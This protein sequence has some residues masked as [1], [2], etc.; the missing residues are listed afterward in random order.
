MGRFWD[1]LGQCGDD[2]GTIWGPK[3][4]ENA[5]GGLLS[6]AWGRT[7]EAQGV[8][9]EASGVVLG[10]EKQQGEGSRP[11]EGLRASFGG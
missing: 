8:T 9:F 7:F 3:V 2:F 1:D 11:W 4:D 5:P 6:E 10:P